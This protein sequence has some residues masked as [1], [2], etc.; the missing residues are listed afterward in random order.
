[1]HPWS[2]SSWLYNEEE[3]LVQRAVKHLISEIKVELNS[4]AD[5]RSPGQRQIALLALSPS[6]RAYVSAAPAHGSSHRRSPFPGG[7]PWKLSASTSAPQAANAV[8]AR[9]GAGSVVITLW[10]SLRRTSS[11]N[12]G[13]WRPISRRHAW[14][15][16]E[17]GYI[18]AWPSACPS[19]S[20]GAQPRKKLEIVT[21]RS[22]SKSKYV[23]LV[24]ANCRAWVPSA[25][26]RRVGRARAGC[27]WSWPLPSRPRSVRGRGRGAA[28][29]PATAAARARARP[30]CR[31]W[32]TPRGR[33]RRAAPTTATREAAARAARPRSN[34]K[35]QPDEI[36]TAA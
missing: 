3:I 11:R 29:R 14:P 23:Q 5:S 22:N 4:A 2:H 24:L 28:R 25:R 18:Y 7:D 19:R 33:V 13:K 32:T 15:C 36:A 12:L 26:G 9:N 16:R 21:S 17:V 6:W 34:S 31:R 1:M 35:Y 27:C 8:Q 30:G 10:E 20:Q